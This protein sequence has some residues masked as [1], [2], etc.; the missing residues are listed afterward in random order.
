VDED[1]GG[2]RCE[3]RHGHDEC[4][5]HGHGRLASILPKES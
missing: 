5:F 3:E 1:A 4:R 2:K